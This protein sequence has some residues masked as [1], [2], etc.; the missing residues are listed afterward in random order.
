MENQKIIYSMKIAKYEFGKDSGFDTL[1]AWN[2]LETDRMEAII[3]E[4]DHVR[5]VGGTYALLLANPCLRSAIYAV[6]Y[7]L[8]DCFDDTDL[9]INSAYF[10]LRAIM[11]MNSIER[12]ASE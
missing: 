5:R 9:Y 3:V 12:K 10:M 4:L 11:K 8:A 2:K 7:R 6:F 1:F